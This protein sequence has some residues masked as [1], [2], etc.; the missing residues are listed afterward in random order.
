LLNFLFEVIDQEHRSRHHQHRYGRYHR[1]RRMRRLIPL[2][3]RRVPVRHR[4]VRLLGAQYQLRRVPAGR[5]WHNDLA[6]TRRARHNLTAAAGIARYVLVTN[7][8]GKLE[9][10]HRVHTYL[11]KKFPCH[12]AQKS[13]D[14]PAARVKFTFSSDF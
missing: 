8:T 10:A 3:H 2:G 5:M 11:H 7:R 12:P 9:F 6:V 13:E 14:P 4:N 1:Q